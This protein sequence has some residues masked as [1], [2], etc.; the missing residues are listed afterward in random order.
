MNSLVDELFEAAQSRSTD[1]IISEYGTLVP[2]STVKNLVNQTLLHIAAGYG[3]AKLAT[4]LLKDQ[5]AVNAQ[6]NEGQ[7]PLHYA[8]CHAHYKVAEILINASA[9]VNVTDYRGWSPLHFVLARKNIDQKKSLYM[10]VIELLLKSGADP[11][12]KTLSGKTCMS[13]IADSEIR[14]TTKFWSLYRKLNDCHQDSDKHQLVNKILSV[15]EFF[16]FV[17]AGD[18][19]RLKC[20]TTPHFLN[21]RLKSCDDITPLHR[22][23]GYNHLEAA[24]FFIDEGADVNATD[25]CGRI[26]LHNAAQ[27]GHVEMIELLVEKGSNINKQDLDG[28]SPL[29]VAASNTTFT[30]CLTLLDL[31]AQDNLKCQAGKIPYDLAE[32]DDVKEV[33][34][35]GH[36]RSQMQLIPSTSDQAIYIY[37]QSSLKISTQQKTL[38]DHLMLDSSSE[39]P[40][41]KNTSSHRKIK[42]YPL[43]KSTD[44]RY[45]EIKNRMLNTIRI[46]QNEAGGI[47]KSYKILSIELLLHEEVWSKYKL[48]CRRLEINYGVGSLNETLL[49]HGSN[50]IDNIVAKGFDEGYAQR[51]GMFGAGIYFAKHSSKSNQYTFGYGQGCHQHSD[52]S[53]YIC[54]RKMIYAQVALGRSFTCKEAMPDLAHAPPQYSSVIGTPEATDN[55]AYPEY[56][57]YKGDQAY[58]LFIIR[59]KIKP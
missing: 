22:T 18:T 50:F 31:G 56:A 59:Y 26:P 37:I 51:N 45:K 3:R 7:T 57:I 39:E 49:F 20:L 48:E 58:P 43:D 15:E 52:K 54:E 30:A 53:C 55:L 1:Y 19:Q 40:L 16:E 5:A 46:H 28:Y 25:R 41:F 6:D 14:I 33:L 32:S 2:L 9:T 12:L 44:P 17:R 47:F 35:S 42:A 38:P 10:Q 29:H 34:K 21:S 11:Y 36:I 4:H 27:Y 24:K 23:A 13:M 8:C